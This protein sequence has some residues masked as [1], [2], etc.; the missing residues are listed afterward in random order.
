L[1]A[2]RTA[3]AR[4]ICGGFADVQML[5]APGARGARNKGCYFLTA[6][7]GSKTTSFKFSSL[8]MPSPKNIFGF[9]ENLYDQL[10]LIA[11]MKEC[12]Y[13]IT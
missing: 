13:Q 11:K 6:L 12:D 8:L 2:P 7:S 5:R 9:P 1:R 4:N 3:G 10:L